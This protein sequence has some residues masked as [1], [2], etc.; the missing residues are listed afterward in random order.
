MPSN[1]TPAVSGLFFQYVSRSVLS[2]IGLS[3]YIL[4]DTFFISLAL[5]PDGLTALNLAIPVS[6][7]ISGCGI[8]AGMGGSTRFAMAKGAGKTGEGSRLFGQTLLLVLL[9]ALPL[10]G[11]G[12][13]FSHPLSLLLGADEVT[14]DNT[15]IYLKTLLLFSPAFLLNQAL[16]FFVRTDGGPGLAMA[17]SLTGSFSNILLDW[18]FLFPLRLGMFGAVLATCMAPLL[19]MA[20]CSSWFRQ[21]KASF[22]PGLPR[23]PLSS[24]GGLCALGGG[25]LI[26]ELSSGVV[27]V[28]FNLIF[29]RLG[30]NNAVAAYGIVANLALVA[31]AVF[32]GISQ[33]VQPLFSCQYGA[34][35]TAASRRTLRL[36]LAVSLGLAAVMWIAMLLWGVPLAGL[37]NQEGSAALT[38][39]A[40][41]GLRIY[42]F[43]FFSAGCGILLGTFF[44]STGH[45]GAAMTVSLL[46]GGMLI[47]PL[48]LLASLLGETAVWLS[49]PAAE[50]LTALTALILACRLYAAG[51]ADIP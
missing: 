25:G 38:L 33:G 7:L 9:L 1:K 4:A 48:A 30:G 10:V 47:V 40:A 8:M 51:S 28:L 23:G 2:M 16:L 31:S 37:F 41:K 14:L 3:L 11:T 12:L 5:G 15:S 49:I 22:R 39:Q 26:T 21:G 36:G 29:L 24:L 35:D 27:I 44:S 6:S 45:P 43:G 50:A 46:R 19:S 20:V 18:V 13:L 42:F 34:G 32:T 17:A